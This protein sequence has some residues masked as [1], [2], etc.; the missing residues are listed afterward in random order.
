MTG[1]EGKEYK[2]FYRRFQDCAIELLQNPKLQDFMDYECQPLYLN[3]KRTFGPF[4]SGL[5]WE[6]QEA[7]HPDKT[8]AN[9]IF[10]SDETEFFKGIS[11]H[12]V[13]SELQ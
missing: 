7:A 12:P 3:G 8:V 13:F 11:A 10:Y 4:R 2:F 1:G 9:M 6:M 5:F